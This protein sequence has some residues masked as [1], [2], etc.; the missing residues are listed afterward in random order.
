MTLRMVARHSSRSCC[1]RISFRRSPPRQE[2][3]RIHC[4][5]W[6]SLANPTRMSLDVWDKSLRAAVEY[7]QLLSGLRKAPLQA[8]QRSRIQ[9]YIVLHGGEPFALPTRYLAEILERFDE[10]AASTDGEFRLAVQTNLLALNEEKLAR[11][12]G[13]WRGSSVCRASS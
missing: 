7:S 3:C 5:E 8:G 12:S 2:S 6:N 13:R 10:A 4:Y 1:R 11:T 9:N